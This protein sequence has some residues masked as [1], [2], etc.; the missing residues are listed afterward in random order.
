[1]TKAMMPLI[2]RDTFTHKSERRARMDGRSVGGPRVETLLTR[3]VEEELPR[4][5]ILNTEKGR[6]EFNKDLVITSKLVDRYEIFLN[7][8]YM[9]KIMQRKVLIR[10]R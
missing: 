3:A 7:L 8:R 10:S 1:M 5:K 4:A 2:K 9:K 6:V